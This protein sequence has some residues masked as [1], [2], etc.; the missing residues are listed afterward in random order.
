MTIANSKL[1]VVL[2]KILVLQYTRNSNEYK[3]NNQRIK[4]IDMKIGCGAFA[5]VSLMINNRL[6]VSNVG[7]CHSFIVSYDQKSKEKRINLLNFQHDL[8][9][10][11]ERERLSAL[12]ADVSSE[13]ASAFAFPINHTRC[14]GDFKLKLYYHEH[15]QLK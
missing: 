15:E 9:N 5:W 4:E 2:S 6:F 1:S 14:L 7:T 8:S 13:S 10:P 11:T 12:D 3:I